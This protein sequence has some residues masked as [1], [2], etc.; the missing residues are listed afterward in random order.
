MLPRAEESPQQKLSKLEGFIAQCP[1]PLAEAVP[2]F[3]PP[4][5]PLTTDYATLTLSPAQQKQKSHCKPS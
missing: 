1:L 4:S 2:L 3:L 5:L